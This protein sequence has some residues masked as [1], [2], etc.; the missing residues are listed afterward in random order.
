MC[1]NLGLFKVLESFKCSSHAT[2][3]AG[4]GKVTPKN[5]SAV[6][7][8]DALRSRPGLRVTHSTGLP[9]GGDPA[10]LARHEPCPVHAPRTRAQ[11]SIMPLPMD[12]PGREAQGLVGVQR[13]A[14]LNWG[15]HAPRRLCFHI[16]SRAC[17]GHLLSLHLLGPLSLL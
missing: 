6:S 4:A 5:A 14:E 2:F 9:G 15:L 11:A 8:F 7:V 13:D 12:Q 1:Q 16:H 17:N 10:A 3:L